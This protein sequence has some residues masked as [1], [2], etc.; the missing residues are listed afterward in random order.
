MRINAELSGKKYSYAV[1]I[2]WEQL[3]LYDGHARVL[4]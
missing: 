1:P 3:F 2:V 4:W